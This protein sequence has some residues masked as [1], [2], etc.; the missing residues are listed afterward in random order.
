MTLSMVTSL[1]EAVAIAL[2]IGALIEIARRSRATR[3]PGLRGVNSIIAGFAL[4]LIGSLAAFVSQYAAGRAM[5]LPLWIG[6]AVEVLPFVTL[7]AGLLLILR[8]ILVWLPMLRAL[9]AEAQAKAATLAETQQ[10]LAAVAAHLPGVIFQVV[11]H[12]DGRTTL[13]YIDGNVVHLIGLEPDQATADPH[14]VWQRIDVRDVRSVTK[15]LARIGKAPTTI[16]FELRYTGREN[17][18][19]WLVCNAIAA[20]RASGAVVLDGIALD[21]G[22][23]KLAQQRAAD[24]EALLVDA[25]DSTDEG[26]AVYDADRRLLAFN[27]DYRARLPAQIRFEIGDHFDDI[28]RRIVAAGTRVTSPDNHLLPPGEMPPLDRFMAGPIEQLL[29]D[30]RW[31]RVA[32]R[33]TRAGGIVVTTTDITERKRIQDAEHKVLLALAEVAR[34]KSDFLANMSHELRTPLNA[35]IGFSEVMS[36][37]ILGPLSDKYREYAGDI[38]ASARHLLALIGDV[39][40]LSKVEAGRMELA[41]EIVDLAQVATSCVTMVTPS[42]TKGKIA[43]AIEFPPDLPR[44]RGDRR[45]ILQVLLNLLTNAIKFTPENGKV[46]LRARATNDGLEVDIADT[47]IG[48]AAE[49]IPRV[50]QDWGQARSDLTRDGEGTGLGLPLSRRL[51]ELHGG[52]L[53]LASAVGAGTTVTFWFPSSRLVAAAATPNPAAASS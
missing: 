38:T 13:P 42:A 26:F 22:P 53:R 10:R 23:Q 28:T 46:I 34:T 30:G 35:I 17:Q 20:R 43:I 3:T 19:R 16:S 50:M 36:A 7:V 40:D 15:R 41:E 5:P 48:I 37:Q 12:A 1:G 31:L 14:L 18:S 33:P 4:L 11:Q 52:T 2:I 8:G 45:R 24:A 6:A 29:P 21:V 49:D 47:G 51:M 27:K 25:I 9:S 44:I 32:V 39:L